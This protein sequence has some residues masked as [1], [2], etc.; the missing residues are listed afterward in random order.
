MSNTKRTLPIHEKH[1]LEAR[2]MVMKWVT[3]TD[4]IG[5]RRPQIRWQ[6]VS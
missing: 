2:H 5:N 3:V 6:V 4:A 1:Q